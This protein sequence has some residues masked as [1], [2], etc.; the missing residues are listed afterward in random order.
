MSQI[1]SV[2]TKLGAWEGLL[3]C[4][5]CLQNGGVVSS[6]WHTVLCHQDDFHSEAS[7][8]TP[9]SLRR[10]LCPSLGQGPIVW[11]EPFVLSWKGLTNG[12]RKPPEGMGPS[13]LISPC[14]LQFA[15]P[16]LSLLAERSGIETGRG[17][18]KSVVHRSLQSVTQ[19]CRHLCHRPW[20]FP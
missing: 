12:V 1:S 19:A 9:Q 15:N 5:P 13:T 14:S 17:R 3:S 20:Y 18:G 6:R 8:R 11:K 16:R 2:N 7:S 4:P 10:P